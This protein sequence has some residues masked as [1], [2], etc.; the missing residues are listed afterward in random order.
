MT[1]DIGR[2][3]LR[4]RE[5]DGTAWVDGW[6]YDSGFGVCDGLLC[7]ELRSNGRL[8]HDRVVFDGYGLG[9]ARRAGAY[10]CC[11]GLCGAVGGGNGCCGCYG[12]GWLKA[13]DGRTASWC[14]VGD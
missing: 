13:V 9:I 10:T 1:W 5:D 11:A 3:R 14:G 8:D 6:L 2:R 12:T 4:G 7:A